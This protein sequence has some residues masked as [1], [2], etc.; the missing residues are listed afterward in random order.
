MSSD[1]MLD[2]LEKVIPHIVYNADTDFSKITNVLLVDNSVRNY[3]KFVENCNESTFSIT[4]SQRTDRREVVDLLA[5]RLPSIYR[6]AIVADN[7][8]LSGGKKLLNNKPYFEDSDLVQSQS[9]YSDNV[10][11]IIDLIQVHSVKKIDYLA[12]YSLTYDS[13]KAYY[14]VLVKETGVL[15][16]ASSDRT[17]NIQYGGDWVMESTGVDVEAVYFTSGISGYQDTLEGFISL[18]GTISEL[19]GVITYFPDGNTLKVVSDGD[20]PVTFSDNV[21]LRFTSNLTLNAATK[22]F[23]VNLANNVIIN[24]E[25]NTV[26]IASVSTPGYGG[27]V[28]S[29]SN[30]TTVQNIGVL[31][32]GSTLANA[33]GWVGRIRF[34]GTID[35]C[36]S[37]GDIS[38]QY[39][40]GIAGDYAGRSGTCTITNCYSTGPISYRSGGIA[41]SAGFS[42]VCTI[43]N[44]YSTGAISGEGGGGIAGSD[45]GGDGGVCTITNC[46]STGDISGPY[47]G[48]IVGFRTGGYGGNCTITNC[49]STGAISAGCGGIAGFNSAITCVINRCYVSGAKV[50][51]ASEY[52]P[53]EV[54]TITVSNYSSGWFDAEASKSGNTVGLINPSSNSKWKLI[55]LNRPWKLLSFLP[56]ATTNYNSVT[57]TL[58]YTNVFPISAYTNVTRARLFNGTTN[59]G[60]A[61]LTLTQNSV[62]LT[63]TTGIDNGQPTY[64]VL[65]NS[66]NN[67]VDYVDSFTIYANVTNVILD[68]TS[69]TMNTGTTR[70]LEATIAPP[71][72]NN[73]SVAWSSSNTNVATVT[74]GIV[75][76]R[77]IPG[78]ATITVR[79]VDG[80]KTANCT[81]KVVQPVTSI[82]LNATSATLNTKSKK[83]LTAKINP[84]NASIKTINWTSS[85]TK[86]ATVTKNGLVTTLNVP[87]NV[88]IT[89]KTVSGARV[90]TCKIKVIQRVTGVT[91]NAK[92]ATLKIKGRR[93]LTATIN[94]KD[95]SDKKVKWISSNPRVASVNSSGVVTA[96]NVGKTTITVATLD[97]NRKATSVITVVK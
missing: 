83:Q 36:Y 48:G 26:N 31:S 19:G 67:I 37:T 53:S 51:G 9:S 38:G 81:V 49:Y 41:C 45:T 58:T 93:R 90:A 34:L 74:S 13:W 71:N 12:C 23:N 8:A 68:I 4:F 85:N 20:W 88:V 96:I 29:R 77:N 32:N 24:G 89:A 97:G 42:G 14:S 27:L 15:V 25:N 56:P 2:P 91:L 95:A 87:G 18:S 73:K 80:D 54:V 65:Y 52:S 63:G 33:G 22:Y 76:A 35:N 60:S 5:S 46:Y 10:Q 82:T 66:S 1:I 57:G 21:T 11:F 7:S 79:T 6:I 84:L 62:S 30:S 70:Q 92:T 39:S 72:A 28:N 69:T 94:P 78:T 17:G 64:L 61:P 86:I 50:T 59:Y 43:S 55:Y 75:T 40:G 47:S 3:N 44:C 16:G